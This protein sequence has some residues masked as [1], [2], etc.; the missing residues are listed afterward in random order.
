ML[1][2][3][4]KR[5]TGVGFGAF[6]CSSLLGRR[7][8]VVSTWDGRGHPNFDYRILDPNAPKG[9]NKTIVVPRGFRKVWLGAAR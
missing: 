8:F 3:T 7:G 5:R 1:S 2:S 4:E 6:E 9:S